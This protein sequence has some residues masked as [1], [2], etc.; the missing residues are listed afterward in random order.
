M[1]QKLTILIRVDKDDVEMMRTK[2]MKLFLMEN[3]EYIGKRMSDRLLFNRLVN[4]Y[5]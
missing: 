1:T 3:P 4:Y 5:L 2:C